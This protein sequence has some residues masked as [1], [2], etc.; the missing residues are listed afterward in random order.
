MENIKLREIYEE[1]TGNEIK[2]STFAFNNKEALR[3]YIEWYEERFQNEY[4]KKLENRVKELE[5][6]LKK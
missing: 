6:T 3:D 1:E 4:V 5:E 2:A